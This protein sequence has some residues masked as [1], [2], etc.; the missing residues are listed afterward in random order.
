MNT[1][2]VHSAIIGIYKSYG[3][4]HPCVCDDEFGINLIHSG[5]LTQN[6]RKRKMRHYNNH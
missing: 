1:R 6:R 2:T 5:A 3:I 4:P